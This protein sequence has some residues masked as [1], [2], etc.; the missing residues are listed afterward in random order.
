MPALPAAFSAAGGA[1]VW[2]A[3]PKT[4]GVPTGIYR[5]GNPVNQ[6]GAFT[7]VND[8]TPAS[9]TPH[10]VYASNVEQSGTAL[11]GGSF[12]IEYGGDGI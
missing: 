1:Y 11:A 9:S 7:R 6:I 3:V 8:W 12:R 4:Q 10:Y 5:A 2:F